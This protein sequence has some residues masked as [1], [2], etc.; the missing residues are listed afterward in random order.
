[1]CGSVMMFSLYA[2]LRLGFTDEAASFMRWLSERLSDPRTSMSADLGPLRV[3]Y[4]LD[5]TSP[6]TSAP[7][8]TYV[9]TPTRG[10]CE[11]VTLPP[12]SCSS[13]STAS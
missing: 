2:L 1:M 13:T 5:G 8:T 10:R 3:L 9:A 6:P 4:D 12:S 11:S 7:W